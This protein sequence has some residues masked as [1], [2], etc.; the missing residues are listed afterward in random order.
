MSPAVKIKMV[1]DGRPVTA[2]HP[3]NRASTG[4]A[5]LQTTHLVCQDSLSFTCF[6]SHR[7]F[8]YQ[9]GKI[10]LVEPTPYSIP[11]EV[12]TGHHNFDQAFLFRVSCRTRVMDYLILEVLDKPRV[13]SHCRVPLFKTGRDR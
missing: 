12:T 11:G 2:E 10:Q 6:T 9:I 7:P 13:E 5:R 3:S 8:L 1:V 4:S